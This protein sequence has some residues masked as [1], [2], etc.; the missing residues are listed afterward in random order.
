MRSLRRRER[1]RQPGVPVVQ[2][3]VVGHRD[4]VHAGV[5]QRGESARRGGEVVGLRLRLA[6]A[7]DRGLQV[8]RRE[9]GRL[10]HGR[11]RTE[12]RGRILQ[13]PRDAPG[14]VHISSEG[15]HDVTGGRH[16][17]AVHNHR[18]GP[19]G[20]RLRDVPGRSAG[21]AACAQHHQGAGRDDEQPLGYHRPEPTPAGHPP[22]SSTQ[23]E[24]D[25]KSRQE[26]QPRAAHAAP[27]LIVLFE[28]GP[29]VKSRCQ[30]NDSLLCC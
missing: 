11:D 14:E 5:A 13:Q 6:S 29:G 27:S 10:E 25:R 1:V 24:G 3:V 16:Q 7:G 9:V 30:K 12:R 20:R 26:H 23:S 21:R 2:D 22:S 15:Q 28:G 19:I 17:V 4:Q 18:A 8:H